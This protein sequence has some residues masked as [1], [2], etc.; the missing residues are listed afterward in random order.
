MQVK[1]N[2]ILIMLG[3]FIIRFIFIFAKDISVDE[4]ALL[5][6]SK[7]PLF[8]IVNV[9]RSCGEVHPP[10]Y[11]FF[12]HFWQMLGNSE[13]ILRLSS[14]IFSSLSVPII[15]LLTFEISKSEKI[16]YLA[17]ILF[18]I[19]S[20][21]IEFACEF[22]MYSCLTFLFLCAIYTCLKY[23]DTEENKYLIANI[24]VGLIGVSVHFLF[25]F[26]ILAELIIYLLNKKIKDCLYQLIPISLFCYYF[27]TTKS[28]DMTIRETPDMWHL[29]MLFSK[30][31]AGEGFLPTYG[32]ADPWDEPILIF[33][34][35]GL[36]FFIPCFLLYLDK[37]KYLLITLSSF[38]IPVFLL[39]CFTNIKIFEYKYFVVMF[40]F[41]IIT[42]SIL[43][44]KLTQSMNFTLLF[45]LI[46]IPANIFSSISLFYDSNF[47]GPDWRATAQFIENNCKE[48]ELA[49]VFP[50][51]MSLPVDYYLKRKKQLLPANKIDKNFVEIASGFKNIWF[52][53]LTNHPYVLKEKPNEILQ[54]IYVEKKKIEIESHQSKDSISIVKYSI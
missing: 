34:G 28:Q 25:I 7:Y 42:I 9:M 18:C 32:I 29:V 4:S 2:V 27:F 46:F 30:M 53:S 36:L 10:L 13:F 14:V 45:L 3:C 50:S 39:S 26:C 16:S 43:I 24:I 37:S 48:D 6:I 23:L 20:F 1:K 33:G 40:P 5:F 44:T 11:F 19:S 12:C 54:Y 41:F 22:R 15:W 52:C 31:L 47:K 35:I 51:M 8:E 21:D 38:F 49:V 17:T